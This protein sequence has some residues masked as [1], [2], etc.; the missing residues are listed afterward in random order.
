VA[1]RFVKTFLALSAVI[2][3]LA[4]IFFRLQ[5]ESGPM[6]MERCR[7]AVQ[8]A[9]SWTVESTSHSE[10]PNNSTYTTTTRTKV[11]CPD[12]FEYF[13]RNRTPDD[14]II[15]QSTIHTHGA[16]YVVNVDGKWDQ[17]APAGNFDI[18]K[19]CGKGPALVQQTLT[20]AI[21]ELPRRRAGKMVKGKLR[22]IDGVTCREWSLEFGNEWPQVQSYT[23][24]IDRKTHLPRRLTFEGYGGGTYD[25]TGWNT[26]TVAPPPL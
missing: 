20:N 1:Q 15:G 8:Q 14:V 11:S 6:E 26:T 21:F 16:S 25:F 10:S 22:T 3:L 23:I 17:N 7:T 18:P 4:L 12:D 13:W 24:C 9:K 19:E 2:L 5:S